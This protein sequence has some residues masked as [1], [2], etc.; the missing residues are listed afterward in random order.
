MMQSMSNYE[1]GY[2]GLAIQELIGSIAYN[3]A[4]N[5]LCTKEQLRYID[6]ACWW[7]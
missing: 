4:F 5:Q 7:G 1:L 6:S 3:S 2:E